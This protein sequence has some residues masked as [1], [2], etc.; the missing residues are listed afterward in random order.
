M[1][2]EPAELEAS[3]FTKIIS[4]VFPGRF[5]W[6]GP[7][8]VAF[9][10]I[11]PLMPGHTLIVPRKQIDQWTD[12]DA[13]LWQELARVQL[14]VGTALKASFSCSRIG[15]IIAGLEVPHCHIHLIPI[16]HESDLSFANAD[17]SPNP[18]ALDEAAERIRA[19]LTELGHSEVSD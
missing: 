1:S 19:A 12:V 16:H 2:T 18:A 14:A 11:A 17:P 10:T 6:K 3:V 9:L 15:S 5:V 7:E 13:D 4:G 8:V